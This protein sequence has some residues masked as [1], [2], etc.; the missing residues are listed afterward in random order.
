[1]DEK[2][3]LDLDLTIRSEAII[4]EDK[5]SVIWLRNHNE[6]LQYQ[7]LN[8]ELK[9][10]KFYDH[11][12]RNDTILFVLIGNDGRLLLKNKHTDLQVFKEGQFVEIPSVNNELFETYEEPHLI[13]MYSKFPSG[14][15]LNASRFTSYLLDENFKVYQTFTKDQF[16]SSPEMDEFGFSVFVDEGNRIYGE[17]RRDYFYIYDQETERFIKPDFLK[18]FGQKTKTGCFPDDQ[19]ILFSND[20]QIWQYDFESDV[21]E[22][23]REELGSGAEQVIPHMML[24]KTKNLWLATYF[25]AK[26]INRFRRKF[27][28]IQIGSP[29][30]VSF[31][32]ST[33]SI[34]NISDH[35][36]LI[37]AKFLNFIYDLEKRT[38]RKLPHEKNEMWSTVEAENNLWGVRLGGEGI[39]KWNKV[40]EKF[41]LIPFP[42]NAKLPVYINYSKGWLWTSDGPFVIRYHIK[43]QKWDYMEWPYGRVNDIYFEHENSIFLACDKGFIQIDSAF[44]VL[45]KLSRQTDPSLSSDKI[46]HIYL[47]DAGAFW[48]STKGGGVNIFDPMKNTVEWINT[49]N[50]LPNN[51]VYAVIPDGR[52]YWMPTDHGLVLLDRRTGNINTFFKAQGLSHNEFNYPSHFKFRDKIYLGTLDGVT[53]IDTGFNYLNNYRPKLFLTSI[54]TYDQRGKQT[55]VHPLNY[56]ASNPLIL[57]Q[58]EGNLEIKFS[59]ADYTNSDENRFAYKLNEDSNEWIQLGNNPRLNLGSPA[60]GNYDLRVKGFTNSGITSDQ[61]LHIPIVVKGPFTQSLAFF[62]ILVSGIGLLFYS[63]YRI[64]LHQFNRINQVRQRI[65][66]NLH[67]EVGSTMTHIALESDLLQAKI[68]SGSEV[69]EKLKEIAENSREASMVMSDIVW[70][71]DSRQDKTKNLVDRMRQYLFKM[72]S[73]KDIKYDFKAENLQLNKDLAPDVRQNIYLIF[74]EAIHNVVKH[75][76]ASY[77]RVEMQE[78]GSKLVLVIEDNG[79]QN[80]KKSVAVS[81]GQGLRNMHYRAKIIKADLEIIPEPNYIVK[82]IVKLN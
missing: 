4:W 36:L 6:M 64:R 58:S 3:G 69:D 49:E 33:R 30:A 71:F 77:V 2:L 82:L 9:R 43:D 50:G 51:T 57:K 21:L 12:G 59:L 38:I 63:I 46:Q 80:P 42:I 20:G 27:E 24:D 44:N 81:S 26:R 68:Y 75:S 34:H 74:K 72:L 14:Y 15:F 18:S 1:M 79:R 53:V 54:R 41:D 37:S 60:K 11:E 73:S 35:E 7:P 55:K 61:I 67:D 48:L 8:M 45:N 78:S 66:A 47:D 28:S 19:T 39:Y 5:D 25:G 29:L 17:V 10:F 70:S 23:V 22:I 16:P 56:N 40:S 13:S 52:K 31:P 76:N 32:N 65:A 62:I